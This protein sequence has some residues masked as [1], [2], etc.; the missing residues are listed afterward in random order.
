MLVLGGARSGKSTYAEQV[1]AKEGGDSVLYVATAQA[2]DDEM[3]ARIN[4]HQAERPASWRTVESPTDAGGTILAALVDEQVILV[5]CLTVLVSN[6]LLKFEDPF[7]DEVTTAVQSEV[8]ALIT[9]VE[10][11]EAK[12]IIVSNE[13]GLG[14]VP[15]YPLGR[16]Y[17]DLLGKANQQLA[18]RADKVLFMVAG[19]PMVLKGE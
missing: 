2:F 11:L 9:C 6:V 4:K 13:V 10:K 19:L 15:P 3:Q 12:I 1:A 14:L 5:D 16:A 7:A 18:A 17:R 8:D